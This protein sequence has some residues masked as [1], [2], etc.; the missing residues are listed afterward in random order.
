LNMKLVHA[1]NG[2]RALSNNDFPHAI[3]EFYLVV[4]NPSINDIDTKL[5]GML[6]VIIY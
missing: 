1:H 5:S 4:E 2:Q 6:L 3:R